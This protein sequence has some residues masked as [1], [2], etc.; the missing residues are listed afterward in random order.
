L[1]ASERPA[2]AEAIFC[3]GS[4]DPGRSHIGLTLSGTESR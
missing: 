2:P 1:S 3:M 4:E